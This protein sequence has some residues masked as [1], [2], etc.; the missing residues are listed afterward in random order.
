MTH[1]RV[2]MFG[3]LCALLALQS[4]SSKASPNP[5]DQEIAL[6]VSKLLTRVPLI[7]GHND[8]P[9]EIRE[10]FGG[11]LDRVDL[12]AQ[13]PHVGAKSV[14]SDQPPLMTDIPRLRT[15]HVGAQ[16]WSVFIPV[17]VTGPAAIKMTIEQIDLVKRM[18]RRYPMD[19]EMA[20]SADDVI[21]IHKSGRIA[22]LIGIE[23]GHQIDNS[24]AA[25]R[26][27][28]DLGARY[29]TLTHSSNTEWADSAT[30][31]PAHGGLT[32]FG[33]AVVHEMNK[34]GMIID[35]SHVSA[36]TMKATLQATVAPV[37]FSHSSARAIVDHP[38]NVSDDILVLV[39]KNRGVVMVNF[40][41]GY[42]SDV[43]NNWIN[44]RAAEQ[45]RLNSPPFAG[46]YIGQ[47][48]R[49]KA[50]MAEWDHA[51]PAPIV[52]IADVADHIEHVRKVGGVDSVGLGSDFDGIPMTP[53][54]LDGVDKFPLV[55][56]E[57]ARRG[58]SDEELAKV[59]GGNILRVMRE[60]ERVSARLRATE[61]PSNASIE[62]IRQSGAH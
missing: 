11:D 22:S 14:A 33:R 49:V 19:L 15:G 29:M 8:L 44:D 60:V 25:M 6:R 34:I 40:F 56:E 28:Y 10:R 61:Q 18:T 36:E 58:W 62:P 2:T 5:G 52:T 30:D 55:L 46:R 42:V 16:F 32:D 41:P 54:G 48:E 50:S 4:I 57:L 39:A 38:R 43:F 27:M 3:A 17:S 13:G 37:M 12:S 47:P 24:L 35:L 45:T 51:H 26:Q 21:R 59:A 23:G 20:F 9:W 7:D 31:N 53:R 1:M